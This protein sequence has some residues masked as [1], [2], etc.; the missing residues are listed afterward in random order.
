MLPSLGMKKMSSSITNNLYG[1][2]YW[3][4]NSVWVPWNILYVTLFEDARRKW[5][6]HLQCGGVEFLPGHATALSAFYAGGLAAILTAPLDVV[7]TRLQVGSAANPG[8]TAVTVLRE[9][10]GA[11]GA[12]AF[13][14]GAGARALSIAPGCALSWLLYGRAKEAFQRGFEGG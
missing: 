5:A 6:T 8:L 7:K 3:L 14:Q 9:M 12:R 11:E 10:L 1:Q 4:T 2:G 13:A